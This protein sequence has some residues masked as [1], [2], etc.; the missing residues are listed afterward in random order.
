MLAVFLQTL[1]FFAVIALGYGA[2]RTGFFPREATAWLTKFVFYFALSAMLF[3]FA[4]GMSVGIA[5]VLDEEGD[6]ARHSNMAMVELEPVPEE[7]DLLEKLHRKGFI[8]RDV[9]PA[10]F[11]MSGDAGDKGGG[12]LCLMRALRVEPSSSGR[13]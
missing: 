12:R 1:P 8:H 6:F 9:K 10:N 3:G 7:D 13:S 5:F 2:G 11:V 4:A